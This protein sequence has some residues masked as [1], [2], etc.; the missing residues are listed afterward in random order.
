MSNGCNSD[1][2]KRRLRPGRITS[3][4]SAS[5]D[6]TFPVLT[7]RDSSIGLVAASYT[8]ARAYDLQIG[9]KN[10]GLEVRIML[11]NISNIVFFLSFRI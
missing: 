6:S 2:S 11:G 4:S 9:Y 8:G 3:L 10:H 7:G 5:S 1:P